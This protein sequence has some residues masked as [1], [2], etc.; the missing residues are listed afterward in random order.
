MTDNNA[1]LT[2]IDETSGTTSFNE[3]F[4]PRVQSADGND[5][6]MD[7]EI[8]FYDSATNVQKYL[9]F[10]ATSSDVDGNGASLKE[11]VGFQN[12]SSYTIESTTDLVIGSA[13]IYTT[14]T[15]DNFNGVSS[16]DPDFTD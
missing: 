15:P 5:A 4:S 7:F 10:A 13:G 16:A 1:T 6:F 14:Y 12:L 11:Y 3:A 9:S 8:S 2:D